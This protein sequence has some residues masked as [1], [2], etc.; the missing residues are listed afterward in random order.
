MLGRGPVNKT[1]SV[2]GDDGDEIPNLRVREQIEPSQLRAV[3]GEEPRT[4]DVDT[5]TTLLNLSNSSVTYELDLSRSANFGPTPATQL[6]ELL[7]GDIP[8]TTKVTSL[9]L[10]APIV[11]LALEAPQTVSGG[12]DTN[13][14]VFVTNQRDQPLTDPLEVTLSPVAGANLAK[15]S[16]DVGDG[17]SSEGEVVS[18]LMPSGLGAGEQF[19]RVVR[20]DLTATTTPSEIRWQLEVK[21]VGAGQA[22]ET[23]SATTLVPATSTEDSSVAFTPDQLIRLIAF[24]M[25]FALV[26]TIFGAWTRRSDGQSGEASPGERQSELDKFRAYT[27]TILVLV[28]LVAILVLALNGSLSGEIAGSLIGV[29]AG[30]ALGNSRGSS[31]S[32]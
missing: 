14:T 11:D 29:I 30:Y 31:S 20:V 4:P 32:G 21:R 24:V 17:N 7:S 8:L 5:N 18:W 19:V 16:D 26:A 27:Q 6:T 15:F 1:I 2:E 10:D 13:V 12:G 23:T 25:A 22:L 3:V 9:L 28:I